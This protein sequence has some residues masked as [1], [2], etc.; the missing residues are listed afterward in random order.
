MNFKPRYRIVTDSYAGF[1]R[2]EALEY[3]NKKMQARRRP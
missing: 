2:L 3:V 1:E